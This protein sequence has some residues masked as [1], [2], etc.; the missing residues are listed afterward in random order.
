MVFQGLPDAFHGLTEMGE[1]VD[2]DGNELPLKGREDLVHFGKHPIR[3]R[4]DVHI[5]GK[6]V[7]NVSLFLNEGGVLGEEVALI[8]E[9]NDQLDPPLGETF[10]QGSKAFDDNALRDG[11][12]EFVLLCRID[13]RV[14]E[15]ELFI[16]SSVSFD[17][18]KEEG[19]VMVVEKLLGATGM[20]ELGWP[21]IESPFQS[22]ADNVAEDFPEE[23]I[24]RGDQ[25][26]VEVNANHQYVLLISVKTLDDIEKARL[27]R[28]PIPLKGQMI[29][30][31]APIEVDIVLDFVQFPVTAPQERIF[32]SRSCEIVRISHSG[33]RTSISVSTIFFQAK[34]IPFSATQKE[35][36]VSHL[37]GLQRS[38]YHVSFSLHE[39]IGTVVVDAFEIL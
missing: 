14:W 6:G 19:L 30:I 25:I 34:T 23:E 38:V 28:G 3:T 2:L 39:G 21:H 37:F 15:E 13:V 32:L 27:P 1:L 5:S 9:E 22:L 10:D 12:V 8:E 11:E 24:F 16:D 33:S 20:L 17:L 29:I 35:G 36:N 7:Y 26:H 18:I 31:P 4:Q